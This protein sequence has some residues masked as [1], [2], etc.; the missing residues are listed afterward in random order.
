[1]KQGLKADFALLMVA[2]VWGVSYPITGT[3]LKYMGPYTYLSLRYLLAAIIILPIVFGRLRSIDKKT[4]VGGALIGLSLLIGSVL[5]TVGLLYTTPSKSGFLT[6]MSTVF[7]VILVA[8]IYKKM[9]DLQSVVGVMVAVIGLAFLSWD[10]NTGMNIGDVLTLFCAV[11]F[12]AQLLL[13]DRYARG[14]DIIAISAIQMLVVGIFSLFPAIMLEGMMVPMNRVSIGSIVFT[15]LFCTTL[16]YLAQNKVQPYTKPTHAAIIFL[17]EPVF[18]AI[19]STF[20][21]DRLTGKAL[22]GCIFIFLGMVAVNLKIKKKR[23]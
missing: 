20:I 12:A 3:A 6:G 22:V 10:G 18:S 21:G 1:M 9:P 11:A 17:A 8:A 13:V 14:A 16:A 15:A 19:F 4:L 7:V 5:Q 2:L 23:S